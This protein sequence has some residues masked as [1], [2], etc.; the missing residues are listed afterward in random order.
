[1]SKIIANQ[2]SPRSGDNV[3]INGNLSVGGTVTYEDVSNVDSVGIVTA[4]GGIRIGTGG[5]V[6]PVG[7][8]IVTYYGDGSQ[9]TGIDASSLQD[10]NGTIRVQANTSGVVVSGIITG[11][12][13]GITNTPVSKSL[14]LSS[15]FGR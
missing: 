13:S 2:I 5:T 4:G 8:G 9:L 15:F 11:N 1:M 7:S 3:T 12:G 14:A 6:G 10:T